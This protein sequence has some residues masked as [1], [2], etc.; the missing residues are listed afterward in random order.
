VVLIPLGYDVLAHNTPDRWDV[1]LAGDIF[2]ERET[3]ERAL[4][5]VSK[6]AALGAAIL[7]GDPGRS[8]L[9]KDRLTQLAAYSVP[10]TR[11]LEDNEIKHTAV[12]TLR[13]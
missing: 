9:P 4:A 8:Y 7:I 13:L 5:F 2:Y 6:Q 12:W 10:V 3:A 11:E 1:I